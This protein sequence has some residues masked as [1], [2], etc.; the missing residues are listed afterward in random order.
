[1]RRLL[2]LAVMGA[3]LTVCVGAVPA[4]AA[5]ATP[6]ASQVRLNP[7]AV[8]VDGIRTAYAVL[9]PAS[10]TP[11]LLLNGTGSP[12]AQWDPILWPAMP[13]DCCGPWAPRTRTFSAGRWEDSSRSG[14]S[15]A[16]QLPCT[17]WCSPRPRP[18]TRTATSG[19]GRETR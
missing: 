4:R 12:M 5:D 7:Q 1:M 13:A 19:D 8:D 9:G 17:D 16:G 15:S 14:S 11:L 10:G 2:T 18:V 3:M 6:S